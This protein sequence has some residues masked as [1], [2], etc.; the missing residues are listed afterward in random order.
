M[1]GNGLGWVIRCEDSTAALAVGVGVG[2]GSASAVGLGVKSW[3]LPRLGSER[4]L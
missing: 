1:L 3:G 2:S 4:A